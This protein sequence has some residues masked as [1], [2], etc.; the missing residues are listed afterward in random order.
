MKA[1]TIALAAISIFALQSPAFAKHHHHHHKHHKS[2]MKSGGAMTPAT[3]TAAPMSGGSTSSQ[4]T[5]GPTSGFTPLSS[6][7]LLFQVDEEACYLRGANLSAAAQDGEAAPVVKVYKLLSAR[8]TFSCR[9]HV[10]RSGQ[11]WTMAGGSL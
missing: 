6:S 4:T 8:C 9:A 3:S 11:S 5:P 2:S 7:S 1:P 10:L